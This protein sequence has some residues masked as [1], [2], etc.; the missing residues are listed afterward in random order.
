[1][2]SAAPEHRTVLRKLGEQLRQSGRKGPK[3]A[4]IRGASAIFAEQTHDLGVAA[5]A[6]NAQRRVAILV[7]LVWLRSRLKEMAHH[8]IVPFEGGPHERVPADDIL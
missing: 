7:L 6:G 5:L 2:H 3:E 8:V 1:M 4:R